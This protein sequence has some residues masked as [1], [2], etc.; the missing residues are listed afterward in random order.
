MYV[1]GQQLSWETLESQ[2][3][4]DLRRSRFYTGV[5]RIRRLGV[6]SSSDCGE[7]QETAVPAGG[8]RGKPTKERHRLSHSPR[9]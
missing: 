9:L 3:A 6:G 8:E 4:P 7:T 1:G 2:D 5:Y